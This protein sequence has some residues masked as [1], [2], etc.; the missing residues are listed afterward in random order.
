MTAFNRP[1]PRRM[2]QI[3]GFI[4]G[5]GMLL[6]G[7]I[8]LP[9]RVGATTS[10]DATALEPIDDISALAVGQNHT[11]A[12]TRSGGVKCWGRNHVGQ[13][14]DGSNTNRT[15]PAD[16]SGLGA[17]VIA[18]AAGD[19]HTCAITTGGGVKCWGENA[20]G[21]LGDNTTTDRS[22]PINVNGLNSGV[23]AIAAGWRHTCAVAGG[24]VK[25]WGN[26]Q[27][28]SVGDGSRT[29][30]TTP[31]TVSGLSSIAALAAGGAHSCALS[32]GGAVSCWGRNNFGQLGDGSKTD[33]LTPVAVPALGS[34]ATAISAEFHHQLRT[35]ECRCAQM[36]GAQCQRTVG[37]RHN[38]RTNQAHYRQRAR[39]RRCLHRHGWRRPQLRRN[40]VGRRRV[41]GPEPLR[42]GWRRHQY[43]AYDTGQCRRANL[44]RGRRRCR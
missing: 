16:V 13:L 43:T 9:A 21:Q 10:A 42:S 33:R 20:A 19:N 14:G 44:R 6:F 29:S 1:S 23:T 2:P 12:L 30:R 22:K 11:C 35:H 18:I 38:Y 24:S 4:A 37:R 8:L 32:T 34:T 36:L 17:G 27:Y 26:N 25:C 39:L 40:N 31:V 5:M 3:V 15:T 28:G 7:L 41:L